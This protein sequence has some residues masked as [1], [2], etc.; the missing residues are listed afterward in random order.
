M[1]WLFEF[2]AREIVW[3]GVVLFAGYTVQGMIP[4]L[5]A[6]ESIWLGIF[7]YLF[8]LA[9]LITWWF[10]WVQTLRRRKGS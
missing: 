4:I 1:R 3:I 7:L 5:P 2:I 6:N 10:D 9:T 8:L